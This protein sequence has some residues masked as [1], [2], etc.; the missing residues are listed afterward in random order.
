M[1]PIG[2]WML[3]EIKDTEKWP[4]DFQTGFAPLP[5]WGTNGIPGYTFSDTKMVSIPNN[6]KNPEEAYKFIRYYTTEGAHIRAGGLTAEK[7]V[8]VRAILPAIVGN[9][10]YKLYDILSLLNILDNKKLV[11]NAPMYAPPYNA[12]IDTMFVAECEKYLVGGETLDQCIT[13]LQKQGQDIIK[14]YK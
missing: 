6:A 1:V 7:N 9:N 11:N 12:E 8:S 13:N 5:V 10:P 14:K 2:S 4:H 3:A